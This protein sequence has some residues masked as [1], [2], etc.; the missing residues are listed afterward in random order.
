MKWAIPL[1]LLATPAAAV[2]VQ[3]PLTAGAPGASIS[4]I[5]VSVCGNAVEASG[6]GWRASGVTGETRV[7]EL[8]RVS[9]AMQA[10]GMEWEAQQLLVVAAK[11][12]VPNPT[13]SE[14]VSRWVVNWVLS[15][16]LGLVPWLGAS[17][18]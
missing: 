15:P 16:V 3:I 11:L 14:R 5:Y 13:P 18:Y 1:F 17:A 2:P 10:V 9:A 6:G 7:C 8:L 4:Q 12:V